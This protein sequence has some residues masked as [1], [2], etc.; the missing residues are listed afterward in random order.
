MNKAGNEACSVTERLPKPHPSLSPCPFCGEGRIFLNDATPLCRKGS[1]NCPACLVV[2]PGEV[3]QAELIDCWNTRA[4]GWQPIATAPTDGT[5]IS[6]WHRMWEC[7]V[8]VRYVVSNSPCK[9]IEAT[10]TTQW[11]EDAFTHWR[12]L[13]AHPEGR[14]ET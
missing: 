3:N 11:P 7:P 8:S 10:L 5:M 12:P 1:I 9:W 14:D 13:P 4:S 2:M 6:A